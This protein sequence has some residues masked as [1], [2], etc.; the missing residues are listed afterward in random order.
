MLSKLSDSMNNIWCLI[1]LLSLGG[2]ATQVP[3]SI[4]KPPVSNINLAEV[5]ADPD[6]FTDN[7]VRWG[8]IINN[9][10]NKATNTWM[11]IVNYPLKKN[12]KPRTAGLSNGRFIAKFKGFVDPFIYSTGRQVTVIGLISG[13]TTQPIGDFNYVFPLI[14][15]TS[16][17]L[18]PVEQEPVYMDYPPPPPWWYYD[19]WSYYPYPYMYPYPYH[20]HR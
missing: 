5:I 18:W 9:V 7:E 2:C 8:G 6:Q 16:S 17:Y 11:E 15:V 10:E 14:D 4:S 19:P 13:H 20:R 1:L 3:N 12:G